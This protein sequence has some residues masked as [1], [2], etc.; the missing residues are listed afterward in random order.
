M[1]HP[2]PHPF[3]TVEPAALTAAAGDLQGIGA[4]LVASNA[5]AALA[6]TGIV[7][8]AADEVSALNAVHF[9][10]Q[11]ELY[12][13]IAAHTAVIHEQFA[14]TV[15][16]G[17]DSYADAEATNA[18]AAEQAAHWDNVPQIPLDAPGN[19][20]PQIPTDADWD[21]VPFGA[22][23]DWGS[24][25]TSSSSGS[26]SDFVIYGDNEGNIYGRKIIP[27][28]IGRLGGEYLIDW[29]TYQAPAMPEQQPFYRS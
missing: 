24:S 16:T 21:N 23:A 14:N 19:D 8:A 15:V 9:S 10:A 18:A 7:P 2:F 25:S 22:D 1:S 28:K 5:E 4:Q 12:Q 11:G 17:A 6:T 26:D 3:V 29:Q 20:F 13:V 27:D